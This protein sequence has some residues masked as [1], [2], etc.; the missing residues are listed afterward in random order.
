MQIKQNRTLLILDHA[1]SEVLGILALG[2][3]LPDRLG[4]LLERPETMFQC[5]ICGIRPVVEGNG[6]GG[7]LQTDVS[8][9][10]QRHLRSDGCCAEEKKKNK[11]QNKPKKLSFR[12]GLLA[13]SATSRR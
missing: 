4:L 1:I 11:K 12:S 9:P 13:R 6:L 7:G 3:R 2:H 5:R 8:R 10:E